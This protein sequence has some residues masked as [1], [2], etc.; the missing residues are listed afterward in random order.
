MMRYIVRDVEHAVC[1]RFNV[2]PELMRSRSRSRRIVRPRLIAMYIARDET[3]AS[4]PAIG[5]HF[6][7]DHSTAIH[8]RQRIA[9]LSMDAGSLVAD[10]VQGCREILAWLTPTRICVGAAV[11]NGRYRPDHEHSGLQGCA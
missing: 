5:N 10:D 6:N 8:A 4:Y 3:D 7:R 1:L 2:T 11:L 9:A